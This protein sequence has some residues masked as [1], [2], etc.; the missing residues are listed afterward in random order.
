MWHYW[1]GD[2]VFYY[3]TPKLM[4]VFKLGYNKGFHESLSFGKVHI[5]D[6]I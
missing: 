5:I 4:A 3:E 2:L 1:Y 6:N